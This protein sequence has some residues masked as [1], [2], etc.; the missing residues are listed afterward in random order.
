M[1]QE[2][3]SGVKQFFIPALVALSVGL[4][5]F[6]G[7][8]WQKV[9]T[10][11]EKPETTAEDTAVKGAATKVTA[12]TIKSLFDKDLIKIGKKDSKLIFVE[13]ADPSC[14]YCAIADGHNS[15][16]AASV[17]TNFKYVSEGGSYIPPGTEIEKL[18]KDGKASY[19]YVYYPGHGNGEMGMKALYCANEKGRFW[20]AKELV[21]SN[22]GYNLMNTTVKNDKAQAGVVAEFLKS[23]VDYDFMKSCLE[24]DK[25][26]SRLKSDQEVAMSLSIQGTPNFWI[27]T[28][29]FP[30]AYSYS[31]MEAVVNAALK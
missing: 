5:F 9:K 3:T 14:P 15:T 2:N 24:S 18:T 4:A 11:E 16:L 6:S 17:G 25:Y 8:L 22:D 13:V 26:D 12:D 20:E 23:A 7:T 30:G 1:S 19:M 31:D 27:N 29:N 21:M 28:T 10:T